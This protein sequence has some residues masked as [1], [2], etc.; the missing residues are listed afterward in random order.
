MNPRTI[1]VQAPVRIPKPLNELKEKGKC[2][3][4]T[5]GTDSGF[6]F[7]WVAVKDCPMYIRQKTGEKAR[8]VI[9]LTSKIADLPRHGKVVLT[10]EEMLACE[11]NDKIYRTWK[12]SEWF[13]YLAAKQTA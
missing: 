4:S 5:F 9:G 10:F 6:I 2:F 8:L 11:D 13:P 1:T 12:P 3:L 7:R